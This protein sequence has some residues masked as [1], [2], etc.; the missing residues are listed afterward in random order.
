M[1]IRAE[2]VVVGSGA[3]G[4]TVAKELARRGKDVLI[5]ERG[6]YV[7]NIGTQRAGLSFYDR[8]GLRTSK[9]GIIVYR[10]LMVGGT[11][12]V[13]CGNGVRVL[14]EEL[15]NSGVDLAQEFEEAEKELGIRPLAERLIGPGSRLIMDA[16]NRLGFEM[17][18]MPK[19][20]DQGKCESC[21]KCVLGCKTGAKWSTLGF[22]KE[23]LQKGARIITRVEVRSVVSH[24]GRAVGLVG[25]GPEGKIRIY[26]DK[27]I[28]AAGGISSPVILKRSGIENTGK[29]FFADLFNVTYGIC[30]KKDINLWNEPS[31]AALS[32]KFMR[33]RGFIMAPFIDVP[34][35][36]RWTMSKRKQMKNFRYNNLL[37]IMVKTKDESVGRIT[38][39]ER[40]EKLVTPADHKK[41]DEGASVAKEILMEGGIRKRDI[42]FTKPRGAHPGGS[43]AIGEVVDKDLETEI[44]DLYVCDA[45]VLP[46]SPGAPPIVTIV[47][48][49]KKLAKKLAEGMDQERYV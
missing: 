19:F 40:F 49:A 41:L 35:V 17:G 18:P 33:S 23:A 21:G 4:A 28:L 14:E 16:A 9:E 45:S 48:L 47:A 36:L 32:T 34:L 25:V 20:I 26:A 31:M 10:A 8:C 39:K 1:R 6:P 24:K 12:I 43:A 13:S 46:T 15:K 37:G 5:V 38:I 29:K 3:G 22:V 42:I 27:I 11:T 7:R 44:K 30:R 2:I